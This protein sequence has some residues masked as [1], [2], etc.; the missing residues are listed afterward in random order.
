M[1]LLDETPFASLFRRRGYDPE[2]AAQLSK[3]IQAKP[4]Q[5]TETMQRYSE[6][7]SQPHNLLS[8]AKSGMNM[9]FPGVGNLLSPVANRVLHEFDMQDE[10]AQALGNRVTDAVSPY[11][12]SQMAGA[13]GAGAYTVA[14]LFDGVPGPNVAALPISDDLVKQA[15]RWFGIT[16]DYREAGYIAPDG[17]M[18]DLSGRHYA[19]D[20]PSFRGQRQ[21]DHRE[22]EDLV[23][24]GGTDGMLQF[25]REAG[26]IRY[27]GKAGIMSANVMPTDAQLATIAKNHKYSDDPLIV[28]FDDPISGN[29]IAS[30]DMVR[31]TTAKLK[32]FFESVTTRFRPAQ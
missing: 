3:A 24:A 8:M 1:N 5:P 29:E 16:N 7:V 13:L 14:N 21:V 32:Q 18:L 11:V 25:M 30:V 31:P 19:D 2:S 6:R 22:L 10:T 28:S 12:P 4:V 17:S 15:K 20:H 23:E 27:D 26:M 9:A